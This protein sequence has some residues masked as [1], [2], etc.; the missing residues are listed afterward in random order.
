MAKDKDVHISPKPTYKDLKQRVDD[1]KKE[2]S[3][4]NKPE[5]FYHAIPDLVFIISKDGTYIDFK[6]DH[7]SDL[8]IPKDQIIGGNIRDSGFSDKYLKLINQ[9]I[10]K[11]I[12]SGEVQTFEYEMLTSHGIGIYECRMVKLNEN[13]LL[14]IARNIT[15]HKQIKEELRLKNTVF[16]ASL[17]ANSTAD[18]KGNITHANR[19]FLKVWGYKNEEEVI[20]KS[21]TE[22]FLNRAEL[23]S[24][25]ESLNKTGEWRGEFTARKKDGSTFIAQGFASVVHDSMGD[26]SGYQSTVLDISEPKRSEEALRISEKRYRALFEDNNDAVFIFDLKGIHLEA[27]NKAAEMM[28]CSVKDLIGRTSTNFIAESEKESSSIKI[29]SLLRGEKLPIYE[30]LFKKLD[31]TEFPGE[32]NAS[33]IYDNEGKPMHF[34]NIV[35][36]ITKRKQKDLDIEKRKKFLESFLNDIPEAIVILDPSHNIVEWNPGAEKMFGYKPPEVIG[37]NID[38]LITNSIVLKEAKSFTKSVLAGKVIYPHETIRFRK[39]GK[40]LNVIVSG[41][42]VK[43]RGDL[44]GIVAIYIDVSMQKKIEEELKKTDKLESLS[45]LAG[46]IAHDFNNILTS[47]L[48]NIGLFELFKDDK[49]KLSSKMKKIEA[50]IFRAKNLTQQLLTFSKGNAP[51][52]NPASI[53][54]LLEE[55]V[56]FSLSG[57]NVKCKLIVPDDLW[58]VDIDEG[59]ISQVIQNITINGVQAMPEGGTIEVRAGNVVRKEIKDLPL[60]KSRYIRIEFRDQGIGIP[61][62]HLK[63]IFDPFFTTKQ[64]G[65]GLGLATAFSIIKNHDGLITVE[66]EL[67]KTTTFYIYLPALERKVEEEEKD[68]GKIIKG[69]GSILLMDDDEMILEATGELLRCIGYKVITAKDGEEAVELYKSRMDSLDPIACVILDLTIPNGLGGRETVKEMLKIDPDVKALVS[70]GYSIDSIISEYKKF[71]FVGAIPKPYVIEE[72]SL[73]I[74]KIL[75]G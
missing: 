9:Y 22:F 32:V 62:S 5:A 71:G 49:V 19:S 31:G 20:G 72:L 73:L 43:I 1:L 3:R 67:G 66:S 52:K 24:V 17:A 40:Q 50:A 37:K 23:N 57:S 47:I 26:L 51:V 41:S 13:E 46:G 11:T 45:I 56:N 10:K 8:A 65:G 12:K 58:K 54:E 44:Q 30:R 15:K 68:S 75:K 27:N 59:Q 74:N 48:V 38:D 61:D 7:D 16:E 29:E 60:K 63:N 34:Q 18:I 36:D 33:L 55:T 21:L 14:A 39:D 2:I 42:P 25:M 4:V 6:A 64:K 28:G 53:R 35:R 69:S 70:S